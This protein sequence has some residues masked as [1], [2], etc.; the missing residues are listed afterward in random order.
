[1]YR[2]LRI[3]AYCECATWGVAI[4]TVGHTLAI[5]V[6]MSAM[7]KSTNV[8]LPNGAITIWPTTLHTKVRVVCSPDLNGLHILT[9][10]H[11]N[12]SRGYAITAR[13]RFGVGGDGL[14]LCIV[15]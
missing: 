14:V 12:R 15:G 10:N 6:S 5:L 8:H 4:A 11:T 3:S 7:K 1:M 2:A 9:A 13:V